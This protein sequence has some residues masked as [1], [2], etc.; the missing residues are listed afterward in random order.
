MNSVTNRAALLRPMYTNS[1]QQLEQRIKDAR[2]QIDSD[3]TQL[4][5]LRG[6]LAALDAVEKADEIPNDTSSDFIS[7]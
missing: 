3:T 5:M 2:A 1:A 4:L 7:Q 6:A